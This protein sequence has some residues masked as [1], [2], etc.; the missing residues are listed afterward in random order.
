MIKVPQIK[1]QSPPTPSVGKLSNNVIFG[2]SELRPYSY[3]DAKND[4]DFFIKFLE[5]LK[6]LG[7]IDWNTVNTSARHSFGTEKLN[8]KDLKMAARTYI[9]DDMQSITVFRAKGDNHSF[10]GY[11]EGNVFHIMFIEYNFGDVYSHGKK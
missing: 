8:T 4:S 3:T 6:Q 1:K 7:G 11:R 5:R 2:F 9:P 10:L